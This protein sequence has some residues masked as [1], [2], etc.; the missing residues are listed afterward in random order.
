MKIR[1][2]VHTHTVQG[3]IEEQIGRHQTKLVEARTALDKLNTGGLLVNL[4]SEHEIASKKQ[5][6]EYLEGDIEELETKLIVIKAHSAPR[7]AVEI[8][9]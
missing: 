1:P 3:L 2:I 5:A 9:L 4:Q 8:E 6:I 7:L